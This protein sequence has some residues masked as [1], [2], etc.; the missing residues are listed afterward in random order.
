[1]TRPVD[2]ARLRGARL[3]LTREQ[4][5]DLLEGIA[6]R[7]RY[8]ATHGIAYPATNT[9]EWELNLALRW[10]AVWWKQRADGAAVRNRR[11][12]DASDTP[13]LFAASPARP[14]TPLP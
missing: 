2:A 4:A 14:P 3:Q 10:F 6:H 8:Y 5:L 9:L 12:H 1:M 11:Q 13:E 7:E